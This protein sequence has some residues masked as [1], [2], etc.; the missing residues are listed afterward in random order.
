M[1]KAIIIVLC[2]ILFLCALYIFGS[3]FTKCGSAFILDYIVSDDGKEMTITIGVGSSIGYIRKVSVHQQDGGKLYLDCISA[4]GGIN[5]S[6][7]AKNNYVIP[8]SDDTH[9]ICMY[10]NDSSFEAVLVRD[11]SGKWNRVK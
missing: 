7:G 5:G 2:S 10:R 1:K 4:F 3:G 9:T 6:I 11:T 8:L